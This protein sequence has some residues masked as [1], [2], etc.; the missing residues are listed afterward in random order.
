MKSKALPNSLIMFDGSMGRIYTDVQFDGLF[1]TLFSLYLK[2]KLLSLLYNKYHG[3]I[4]YIYNRICT[5]VM[6]DCLFGTLLRLW[7]FVLKYCK[8]H[9]SE[10]K[11]SNK[12]INASSTGLH[13][14]LWCLTLYLG[15]SVNNVVICFIKI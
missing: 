2:W 15:H 10:N 11:V 3:T 12:Y 9:F 7:D 6:F 1:K 13:W 14:H 5:V 8:K 4:K